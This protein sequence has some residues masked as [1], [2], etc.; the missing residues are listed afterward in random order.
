MKTVRNIFLVLLITVSLA[1]GCDTGPPKGTPVAAAD[2]QVRIDVSGI[3]PGDTEF[4]RYES[5]EGGVAVFLVARTPGGELKAAF[6]ACITCYPH[7]KG[8][9]AEENCVVCV[10][11]D[12]RFS[13]DELGTGRGNCIP[14]AL[15]FVR[16]GEYVVIAEADLA[17]GGK[18]FPGLRN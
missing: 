3:A 8:Y 15:G 18:Y 13:L 9:R 10:Y 14:V 2:G 7:E 6:D 11:C 12:T 1:A 5:A 16:E 17:A 4:F